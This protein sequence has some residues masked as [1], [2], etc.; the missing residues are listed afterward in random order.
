M[1]D[2]AEE[3]A[4]MKSQIKERKSQVEA[5]I[6]TLSRNL[7]NG[8]TMENISCELLYDTPNVGELSFKRSDN[9]L[10]AKT[11]PMTESENQQEM[12]FAGKVI[13][14]GPVAV[15]DSQANIEAFFGPGTTDAIKAEPEQDETAVFS[16]VEPDANLEAIKPEHDAAWDGVGEKPTRKRGR[17]AGSK[18]KV[19]TEEEPF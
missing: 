13:T 14:F 17:P 5:T 12:D 11:R 7:A 2:I 8:Y 3:E 9:G 16:V 1:A 4:V 10:I 18:N 15:E 6:G 19:E